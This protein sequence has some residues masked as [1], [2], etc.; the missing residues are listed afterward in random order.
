M[1]YALDTNI[2]IHLLRGTSSVRAKRDEAIAQS[3]KKAQ[4]AA[5]KNR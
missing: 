4:I 5:D 1:T 3:A 2:V